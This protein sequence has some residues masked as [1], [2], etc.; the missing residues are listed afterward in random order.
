MI[1]VLT[2]V[3]PLWV[4]F[5]WAGLGAVPQTRR[6]CSA[7]RCYHEC[8]PGGGNW[9]FW[10]LRHE[11]LKTGESFQSLGVRGLKCDHLYEN[12][13]CVVSDF[14]ARVSLT[15]LTL[16]LTVRERMYCKKKKIFFFFAT[17]DCKPNL[18]SLTRAGI[19]TTCR[20]GWRPNLWTTREVLK[21]LFN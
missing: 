16:A 11:C 5:R 2:L 9:Q 3:R 18:S 13:T 12:F 19:H 21:T 10:N 17:L 1:V 7:L 8:R 15:V 4:Y 6:F 14:Y 20:E